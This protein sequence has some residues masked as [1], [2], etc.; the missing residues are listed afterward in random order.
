LIGLHRVLA[1]LHNV[2]ARL[3]FSNQRS[4]VWRYNTKEVI[5]KGVC[6]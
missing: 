5:N 1:E 4:I 2:L 6:L 3:L